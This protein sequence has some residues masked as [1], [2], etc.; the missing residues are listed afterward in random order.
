V[1]F[2]LRS[3]W[4]EIEDWLRDH[5]SDIL[6]ILGVLFVAYLIFKAVFPHVARAAMLRGAHPPDEEMEARADTILG[7][8]DGTARV[9]VIIVAVITILPEFG[10]NI[11]AI[12]TGLGIGG[13]AIALGSQQL[14][15]D[16]VNGI[17]LLAEDQYRTGDVV[18]IAGVTG[19]VEAVTLRRTII[20][21]EDGV[22]HSVPNGAI[23]VVSNH[24]R[25]YAQVNV[26][27]RVAYGEDLTKVTRVVE[28]LARSMEVDDRSAA[29]L[30][31]RPRVSRV[32]SVGDTGVTLTVT[33]RTRPTARLDV[34]SDLRRRLAEAF[35]QE[36]IQ[37]PYPVLREPETPTEPGT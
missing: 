33:V 27:V 7:V 21:D 14:V 31:D 11:T 1:I 25:D 5:G 35:L 22:V 24:T 30:M 17:F 15:R 37:V 20:R 28:D 4:D 29:L 18:S 36:N 2:P 10:V 6:I 9:V 13:L 16:A 23:G 19:T 32:D 34:A 8:I 12:V 26:E 3:D